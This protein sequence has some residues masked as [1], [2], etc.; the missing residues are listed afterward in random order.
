MKLSRQR[1]TRIF[2][3]PSGP[4]YDTL[5]PVSAYRL[6]LS[7]GNLSYTLAD[8]GFDYHALARS[9][10]AKSS[11]K[12]YIEVYNINPNTSFCRLGVSYS[13]ESPPDIIADINNK[14]FGG[15]GTYATI[16]AAAI[17]I[18][19]GKV[20]T[21]WPSSGSINWGSGRDPVAGTNPVNTF[22]P[23]SS[24][25]ASVAPF[26]NSYEYGDS[27]D[28]GTIRFDPA[29]MTYPPPS[30]YTAGWSL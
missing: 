19:A 5:D 10:T 18:D 13:S 16:L 27:V 28:N 15:G 8:L 1:I 2:Q 9:T 4:T 23:G 17:D 21:G 7:N 29:N 14:F 25:M 22:T 3:N 26:Y 24:V 12:Y 11:G 6:S 20:W 30:G